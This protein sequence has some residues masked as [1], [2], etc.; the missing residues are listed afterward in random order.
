MSTCALESPET[1][2]TAETV[3]ARL[4]GDSGIVRVFAADDQLTRRL[5]PSLWNRPDRRRVAV[6]TR[7]GMR[8]RS[9]LAADV[10]AALGVSHDV[11]GIAR[12]ADSDWLLAMTWL[13]ARDVEDLIV[14]R[15]ESL[16]VPMLADLLLLAMG[17]GARLWLVM[18]P[19]RSDAFVQALDEWTA[20]EVGVDTLLDA[21]PELPDVRDPA[22]ASP[23]GGEQLE[24]P[25]TSD[26]PPL[27]PD[28]DFPTFRAACRD[29]LTPAQ[30]GAVDALLTVE[31]SLAERWLRGVG[32]ERPTPDDL[33]EQLLSRFAGCATTGELLATTRAWQVALF[34]GGWFLQVDLPRLL[35]VA[36]ATP[37]PA[38]RS[39]QLWQRLAVYRQPHRS[40]ACALAALGLD[41]RDIGAL[42]V[43]DVRR[44][45]S[46]VRLNGH[47]RRTESGTAVYLRAAVILRA[48]H[49]ATPDE[50]LLA[51]PDGKVVSERA[52]ADAI[53]AARAETGLAV[54][55][56]LVARQRLS[57]GR[58]YTRWGLS[59]QR[60]D[61]PR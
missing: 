61:G 51:H 11:T 36:A 52:I 37:R 10:L 3:R 16:P 27:L 4:G 42:T 5:L 22:A 31:L 26:V 1:A 41:L 57:T 48:L 20:A 8:Q 35:S 6:L 21:W 40:A 12:G 33:S 30:F 56:R 28:D 55:S 13:L 59:L 15:A 23:R 25:H 9:W 49:G 39:P 18:T 7:P 24:L 54:T 14:L 34:R 17:G 38:Q 50:P 53:S 29:A 19:P 32:T 45:G 2:E 58:W 46:A 44:D 47:W 60:I 43:A